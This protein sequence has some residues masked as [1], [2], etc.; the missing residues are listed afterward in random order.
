MNTD[1]ENI[2]IDIS[3]EDEPFS[4]PQSGSR[5]TDTT[6]TPLSLSDR[7][8]VKAERK[9][10][11]AEQKAELSK[12][13][14]G[15]LYRQYALWLLIG[16][17]F[18]YALTVALDSIMSI[19]NW[20]ISSMAENFIELLKYVVSTLLGFVFSENLKNDNDKEK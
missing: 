14:A 16:C 8:T 15:T 3:E 5:S 13:Y 18:C 19:N 6:V 11:I 9:A 17:L 1:G 4:S 12:K 7:R 2:T 10:R 20:E